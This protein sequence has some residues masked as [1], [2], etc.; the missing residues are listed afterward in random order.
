[1]D[2]TANVSMY[3]VQDTRTSI[4][5]E[6]KEEDITLRRLNEQEVLS[7]ILVL[8]FISVII[9]LGT[10]GNLLVLGTYFKQIQKNSTNFFIFCLATLDLIS[11]VISLPAE[12]LVLL[13]PFTFSYPWLCKVYRFVAFSADLASGYTIVCIS[14]DRYLR[15]ARPHR[16][17][18]IRTCK[19]AVILVVCLSSIVSSMALYVYGRENV[20]IHDHPELVGSKCGIDTVAKETFVPLLFST[21]ILA[22]FVVGVGILLTVYIKLG[23]VVR[24]W[25]KGKDMRNRFAG[26]I[27]RSDES[28]SKCDN[29]LQ[30]QTDIYPFQIPLLT[31]DIDRLK[32][33]NKTNVVASP[34]KAVLKSQKSVDED[35]NQNEGNDIANELAKSPTTETYLSDNEVSE[36]D[37]NSVASLPVI[38]PG[39]VEEMTRSLEKNG[40]SVPDP[41]V[42]FDG[43]ATLPLKRISAKQRE[44]KRKVTR[45]KSLVISDIKKRI[46]L[47]KTTTMFIIATVAFVVCHV[48]YVCIKVALVTNPMLEDTLSSTQT[49][50][51][52]LAEYSFIVSYAVNP[53]IYNFLNPRFRFECRNLVVNLLKRVSCRF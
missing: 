39:I 32:G 22:A 16:R 5:F 24:R 23:I 38:R 8:V 2:D 3:N 49:V 13:Q 7:A 31:K 50:F 12:M 36:T 40:F 15:I 10:V 6:N 45:K 43:T 37:G 44:Q 52:R 41:S 30:K 51:Y 19:R 33:K 4:C 11:C 42:H 14:F 25:N 18:K 28:S 47:S 9:L 35:S 20:I 1:M 48:P 29:K 53:I 26:T 17:F 34:K 21:M 46:K 27:G